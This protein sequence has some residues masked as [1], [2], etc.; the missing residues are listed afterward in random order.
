MNEDI[1]YSALTTYGKDDLNVPSSYN[2]GKATVYNGSK[3]YI[4]VKLS[5]IFGSFISNVEDPDTEEEVECLVIPLRK[6]GLTTTRKKDVYAVYEADIS[7]VPSQK[8]THL[9]K[10]IVNVSVLEDLLRR[11]FRQGFEG[12]MRPA[13]MKIKK[14][15]I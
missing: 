15:N 5:D 6:S 4:T 10:R 8:Y 1:D 12:H 9:L 3:W 13:S 14:R 11:G 7:Q 2:N